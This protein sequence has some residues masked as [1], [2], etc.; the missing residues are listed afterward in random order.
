MSIPVTG[1]DCESTGTDVATDRMV[2]AAIIERAA[3]GSMT[4]H[5]WLI[6]P[7]IEVPASAVAIHGL[8]T[9]ALRAHG[10]QPPVALDEIANLL[11]SSLNL[12]IPILIYNASFDLRILAAELARYQLES[13]DE[14]LHSPV[15]PVFDP[16]VL[17]RGADRYRKGGRRLPDLME[18]YRL[19]PA[20]HLHDATDDVINTIAVFDAIMGQH[21][22]LP[23][24]PMDLHDWQIAAHR[25]WATH[26]NQ[27]LAKQGRQPSAQVEWP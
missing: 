13:L 23:T 15:R 14:R 16:L 7:G 26:Y 8:T 3:D 2:S 12:G 6:D 1:F 25:E 5:Q 10:E 4:S 17:D 9:Q 22:D 24:D 18:T 11:A 19:S 20:A 21:P 27:W